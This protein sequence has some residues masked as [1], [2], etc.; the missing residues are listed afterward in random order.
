MRSLIAARVVAEVGDPE[1][2]TG[3]I[4]GITDLLINEAL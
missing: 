3:D 4:R 2:N 1:D